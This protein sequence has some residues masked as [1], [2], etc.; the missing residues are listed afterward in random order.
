MSVIWYGIGLH[1]LQLR[2][3]QRNASLPNRQRQFILLRRRPNNSR[4]NPLPSRRLRA[5]SRPNDA[6]VRLKKTLLNDADQ[7]NISGLRLA[8]IVEK[9]K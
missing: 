8:E 6:Y 2:R 4:N 7:L 3:L 9:A 1:P 5:P